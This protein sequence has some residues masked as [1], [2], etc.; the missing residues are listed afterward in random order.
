MIVA[1][2]NLR[3]LL[4]KADIEANDFDKL[5][6]WSRGTTSRY[7]KNEGKAPPL[8]ECTQIITYFKVSLDQFLYKNLEN[9]YDYSG[10]I[11]SEVREQSNIY[12]PTNDDTLSPNLIETERQLYERLIKSKDELIAFLKEEI[13][14]LKK[15]KEG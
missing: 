12:S 15:E 2:E 1:G 13:E 4:K 10:S 11:V 6:Q 3:F 7:Q 8:S 14:R 9:L 5:M